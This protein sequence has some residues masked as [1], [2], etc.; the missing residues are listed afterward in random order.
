MRDD[1]LHGDLQLFAASVAHDL[2]GPLSVVRANARFLLDADDVSAQE[3]QEAVDDLLKAS[4]HMGALLDGL[5]E[6]SRVTCA[7]LERRRIDLSALARDT[8]RLLKR[9]AE[10]RQVEVEIEPQLSVNADEAL[11]RIV[12]GNLF[13]NAFKYTSHRGRA[14]IRF[15]RTVTEQGAAF[16][17]EDDGAGFEAHATAPFAPF[18]RFHD[19][20]QFPGTG[21]GLT[22]VQRALGRLGGRLWA[23]SQRDAGARFYFQVPDGH[24]DGAARH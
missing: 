20:K 3:R 5:L 17:V 12:L 24:E 22:T 10:G 2:R 13:D 4:E 21:L 6:L 11:M 7:P 8:V 1:L 15:T 19:A 14:H 18:R 9:A 23:Q 16:V